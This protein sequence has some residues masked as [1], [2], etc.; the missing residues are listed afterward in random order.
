MDSLDLSL[1]CTPEAAKKA[2]DGINR[3]GD[4]VSPDVLGD[5]R[6][7]VSEL[8]TNS[9]RHGHLPRDGAINLRAAVTPDAVRV[10]VIDGG[11]GFT[12]DSGARTPNRIGGFG[13]YLVN[14]IAS[15]WGVDSAGDHTTRVWF[16]I[17]RRNPEHLAFC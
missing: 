7:L 16:E 1:A 6:L 14:R 12:P 17:D 3:L 9:L 2:R 15:R 10:E 8:V 4:R 13:L 11:V 5:I